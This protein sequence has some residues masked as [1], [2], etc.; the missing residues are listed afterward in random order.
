MRSDFFSPVYVF[1][2]AACDLRV[3]I[4]PVLLFMRSDFFSPVYVFTLLP[5]KTEA[6]ARDPLAI[7]DTFLAFITF[8]AFIAFM[9]FIAT[10]ANSNVWIWAG[11]L[12]LELER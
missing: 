10:I 5:K 9:A 1:K 7:T 11:N 8:I 3:T 6:R 2:P 4:L 12:L